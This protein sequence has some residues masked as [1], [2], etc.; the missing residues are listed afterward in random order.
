MK[1]ASPLFAASNAASTGS[2]GTTR[3]LLSILME[4][5]S[6]D[7]L[8]IPAS[9]VSWS[10]YFNLEQ[11]FFGS[12]ERQLTELE[13]VSFVIYNDN[14]ATSS[15]RTLI[16]KHV[17]SVLHGS[18][19]CVV[20][21]FGIAWQNRCNI[22]GTLNHTISFFLTAVA[23]NISHIGIRKIRS[24]KFKHTYFARFND[25]FCVFQLYLLSTK[26]IRMFVSRNTFF[27]V[28]ILICIVYAHR[29]SPPVTKKDL[30]S[31]RLSPWIFLA[32]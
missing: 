23:K 22:A 13:K 11:E 32:N 10:D 2:R 24:K 5:H 14:I 1:A 6:D 8:N 19:E 29:S 17:L 18:R 25:D 30:L 16:L 3:S 28:N 7:S 15:K 21:L 27:I 12:H 31:G 26:S 4:S 9:S 20:K